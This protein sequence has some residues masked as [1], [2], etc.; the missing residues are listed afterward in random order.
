MPGSKPARDL[1]LAAYG[2]YSMSVSRDTMVE[3]EKIARDLEKVVGVHLTR[4]QVLKHLINVYQ[5]NQLT[6]KAER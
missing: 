6:K 3:L 2:K 1:K 5:T 4:T